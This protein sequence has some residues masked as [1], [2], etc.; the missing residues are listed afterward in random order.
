M[1]HPHSY[2]FI[3]LIPRFYR[4]SVINFPLTFRNLGS[5]FTL[6][7]PLPDPTSFGTSYQTRNGVHK[8]LSKNYVREWKKDLFYA[9]II[10]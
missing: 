8:L 1:K 10:Y 2:V 4:G 5:N 6:H 9:C 7:N 3:S